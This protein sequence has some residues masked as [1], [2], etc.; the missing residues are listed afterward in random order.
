MQAVINTI[1]SG[2]PTAIIEVRRHGHTLT[3][4]AADVLAFL[5]GPAPAMDPLRPSMDG[6]NT[7]AA[8]LLDS[9]TMPTR[10]PATCSNQGLRA[11]PTL[12]IVM[13][14]IV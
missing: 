3:Q 2:V 4:S 6:P 12:L 1:S 8:Q 11:L 13:S 9:G 10:S 14:P 5:T 7:F